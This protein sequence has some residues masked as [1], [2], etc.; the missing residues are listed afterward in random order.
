M[1]PGRCRRRMAAACGALWIQVLMTAGR[2]NA[3]TTAVDPT[4]NPGTGADGG[5]IESMVVQ[6]DRK[7]LVC[8]NFVSFNGATQGYIARLMPDGALDPAFKAYPG[9]WV[10]FMAL[11]PD[12]KIF[13]G[14]WFTDVEGVP[15]NRIARLNADGSL[16]RSFDPGTGCEGKIVPADPN[17]PFLFALALQ[18]DGKLII[19][20]NFVTYNGVLRNG[21]ARVNSDGSLDTTFDVTSGVN[22]WVRSLR[23][24]PN[25]QVLVS[26]WF[27]EYKNQAHNRLMLLN[28]DAS[29]D[30]Q[31]NPYFGD[32]TSVYTVSP[33]T[34]GN[35]IAAGHSINP[36]APFHGE[37]VRLDPTGNYDTTFNPGGEGANDK[38]ET[39]LLAPDG[40]IYIGGYFGTYNGQPQS[41][42]SR[43]NPDGSLD[44]TFAWPALD[45]WVWTAIYQDASRVL[46]CGAFST[47][48]GYSRSG[49]ARL[50]VG[51]QPAMFNPQ[52]ENNTFS[53]SVSTLPGHTYS[54]QY[55]D[56]LQEA[57]WTSLPA[58]PGD[59]T[60]RTLSDAKASV[61]SRFY[62][63]LLDAGL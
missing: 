17:D 26:G 16:D 46:I 41:G 4:F 6:T 35:Y 37:I 58:L 3:Q 52:F 11:Q 57:A 28:G 50:L 13:I 8:G 12:G 49:I 63:V 47:A 36:D 21:L 55:K 54:L 14:G 48:D 60:T 44:Q 39:T 18:T 62:R 30:P 59:G 27:T 2:L 9:Y 7:I 42:F 15:R 38:I 1:V 29:P 43:L 22:S 19:G 33:L 45:N 56:S 23:L 34:N 20:G 5:F 31:F 51:T 25:G 32:S 53:V 61:G 24:Q 10:R 40:K